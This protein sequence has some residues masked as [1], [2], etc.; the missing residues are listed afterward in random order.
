MSKR[1]FLKYVIFLP[2]LV[3]FTS[4]FGACIPHDQSFND[5]DTWLF[6][7]YIKPSSNVNSGKKVAIYNERIYYLSAE[8]S[9]QGV[10]SMQLNGNDVRFEFSVEDIRAMQISNEGFY[11]CGFRN[12]E[13]NENGTYRIFRLYHRDLEQDE[14]SD[15]I[16][17]INN[18]SDLIDKNIWD[19]YFDSAHNLYVRSVE[20]NWLTSENNLLLYSFVNGT[21]VQ[22]TE[23]H[24]L[25]NDDAIFYKDY[26]RES[27]CVYRIHDQYFIL[28]SPVESFRD[29]KIVDNRV[30]IA[31]FDGSLN[32][33][34]LPV[35]DRFS[36]WG[37]QSDFSI[38]WIIRK[39]Q[40]HLVIGGDNGLYDYDL[41][42]KSGTAI[43]RFPKR[44]NLF[45]VYDGGDSILLLT[46]RFRHT[47]FFSTNIR[48]LF[49]IN[50]IKGESLYRFDPQTGKKKRLL[51]L[52]E[53]QA[54]LFVNEHTAVTAKENTIY[55]YDISGNKP[56]L[57][58]TFELG[59]TIVDRANKVDSA[60]GWLFLYRFNTGTQRDEL[61]EKVYIGS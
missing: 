19:F 58:R 9:K 23:Y 5:L 17:Q 6:S 50:T 33:Q 44:E 27:L 11:Y 53:K 47:G 60:G 56:V 1:N 13:T 37:D 3:F 45:A 34:V 43:I 36:S 48:Y 41:D 25:V 54:F 28:E 16:N 15:V 42:A 24:M 31:L 20:Q 7:A 52:G 8:H 57:L 46:R 10:Y 59:Y 21:V 4:F 29:T 22:N 14:S 26:P 12:I 38:R 32:Q 55:I 18:A 49:S 30:S 61:I 51:T 39:N 35:D 2:E 40:N